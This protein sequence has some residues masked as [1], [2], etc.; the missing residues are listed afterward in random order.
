MPQRAILTRGVPDGRQRDAELRRPPVVRTTCDRFPRGVPGRVRGA[1]VVGDPPVSLSAEGIG[2]EVIA[3]AAIERRVDHDDDGVVTKQIGV[4]LRELG[5]DRVGIPRAKRHVHVIG[6][7]QHQDL[8]TDIGLIAAPWLVLDEARGRRGPLPLAVAH[9]AVDDWWLGSAY[10]LDVERRRKRDAG[11]LC[12]G[13]AGQEQG[14]ER[15]SC[16]RTA[17]A[18]PACPRPASAVSHAG[19]QVRP[20]SKG[21]AVLRFF[22][23]HDSPGADA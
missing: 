2:D 18:V 8:G 10:R 9:L 4:A 1:P 20:G 14:A 11:R 3:G 12:A 22:Q 15:D 19:T 16:G 7:V 21:P 5:G 17:C 23:R 13:N 6:V